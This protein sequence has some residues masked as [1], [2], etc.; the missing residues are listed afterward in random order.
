M[1]SKKTASKKTA[2][3]GPSPVFA[4]VL[5]YLKSAGKKANFTDAKA[6]VKKQAKLDLAPIVWGRALSI[7]KPR[8]TKVTK[9]VDVVKDNTVT[10]SQGTFSSAIEEIKE[11]MS[12]LGRSVAQ[13]EAHMGR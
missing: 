12:S 7:G 8:K 13:L 3:K 9:P 10:T 4:S 2:V 5:A 11:H 1:P 6:F